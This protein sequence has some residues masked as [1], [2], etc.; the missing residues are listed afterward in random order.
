MTKI[1]FSF[2]MC[3]MLLGCSSQTPL[4]ETMPPE[5][6]H[7]I[8]S[9]SE[10][11]QTGLKALV[12]LENLQRFSPEC[13][14]SALLAVENTLILFSGNPTTLTALDADTLQ[15]L[16]THSADVFLTPENTTL[17]ILD[18]GI[19][20]FSGATMETVVLDHSL[21][22]IRSIPAPEELS[23][24][25]LLSQDGTT[26]YYCTSTALRSTELATG[27]SR[28]LKESSYPVQSITGLLMEDTVLQLSITDH[29]NQWHTLFL[30][31]ENGQLLQDCS[32]NIL[33]ETYGN[34]FFLHTPESGFHSILFGCSGEDPRMLLPEH[35]DDCFFLG[36][37][38]SALSLSFTGTTSELDLYD[39][40]TGTRRASLSLPAGMIPQYPVQSADGSIWFLDL[41]DVPV[42]C[43]WDPAASTLSDRTYYAAPYA[44]Q[45]HPDYDGLA[46]CTLQ[47]QTIGEKYG[48]RV[49]VYRDATALEPWDY[50]LEYEYQVSILQQELE[51]LDKRLS[52][53]P[54]GFLKTLAEQFTALNICIVRSITGSPESGSLEAVNGIQFWDD[55]D[56]YIVLATDHDTEYALYH[57]LFHM[58]DSVVLTQSTAYDRWDNLNP[59]DFQY[60]NDYGSS[61]NQDDKTWM[62][63]GKEYF[64]D[65]YS[66]SYAKEDRA[67]ILEYAMTAGHDARFRSPFLQAKL[68]QLCIGIRD[69]FHLNSSPEG[70]L[71]EQ[72]LIEPLS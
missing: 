47:A 23:G 30:S 58:I 28:I 33:P 52:H 48:I 14:A 45:E 21:R 46:A 19:S 10:P 44:T 9:V 17:Q 29:G 42:V 27:I 71:W 34:N 41:Q 4:H 53:F 39:L 3:L 65:D 12:S 7:P 62:T 67:R 15:L 25:P 11:K 61:R 6:P 59:P 54:E 43:R 40:E 36:S 72:Y 18:N 22:Q 38:N 63:E 24:M 55:Y 69:A 31:A 32:G 35:Y 1:F 16:G 2:L 64:I 49:L 57:E 20:Y 50:H 26:L 56:S 68:R 5:L 51:E 60:E 8:E 13:D 66:M 37:T 70:F